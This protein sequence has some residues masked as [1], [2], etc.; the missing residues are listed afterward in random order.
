MIKKEVFD[1]VFNPRAV[2]LFGVA[3][4]DTT[5]F[6]Y[7]PLRSML[8]SDYQG[9]LYIVNPRASE[10]A[11][12]RAYP[13]LQD[14]PDEVDLAIITLP[15]S[16]VAD[17][18]AD[19]ADKGV[20]GAVIITA[21]FKESE[22][23]SGGKLQEKIASIA[24][25]AGMIIIGPNSYGMV[26]LHENLN[27]SF[28][29]YMSTLKKG[30]I[31]LLTQSGG[32]THFLAPWVFEQANVGFSRILGLGNRANVDFA[33]MIEYLLEDPTTSVIGMYMEGIDNPRP[34][35]EVSKHAVGVKPVVAFKAGQVEI[36][37]NAAMSHTGSLAG[38]HELYQAAFTQAGIISVESLTELLD[39]TKALALQPSPKGNRI[40]IASPVAG[41][42]LVGTDICEKAGLCVTRFTPETQSKLNELIPPIVAR[43]NPVDWANTAEITELI[44]K[45]ENVD[46]LLLSYSYT[47]A[48]IFPSE[49][50]VEAAKACGKPVVISVRAPEGAWEKEI[51]ELANAGIPIYPMPDRAARA[52]V[53]L[54]KY[55]DILRVFRRT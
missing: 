15:N 16:M 1:R 7:Y 41:P 33:D 49:G 18:L 51:A 24:N 40:A 2:A 19:C 6:S 20:K 21:G 10:V 23:D 27:A 53:A 30:S 26:H 39:V 50:I 3:S 52:A 48:L 13:S 32:I 9:N 29:T 8:E 42:A 22:D 44:L 34:L 31:S 45:D 12:F 25:E 35:L 54:S 4:E 28:T 11:G 14:I 38:R 43:T 37:C 46:M 5:K 55:G 36:S 47:N 17:I